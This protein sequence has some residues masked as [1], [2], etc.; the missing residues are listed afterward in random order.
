MAILALKHNLK[1]VP[2]VDKDNRFLGVVPS[3]AIWETLHAENAEDI[4]RFAGIATNTTA[5][6]TKFSRP[7]LPP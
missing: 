5:F 4:L 1:A 2:V 3:D 6:P 7:L